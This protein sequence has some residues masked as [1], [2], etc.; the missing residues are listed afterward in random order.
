MGP[1]LLRKLYRTPLIPQGRRA[2]QAM[3]WVVCENRLPACTRRGLRIPR[4]SRGGAGVRPHGGRVVRGSRGA[5]LPRGVAGG[6][7]GQGVRRGRGETQGPA[8]ESRPGQEAKEQ[9]GKEEERPAQSRESGS[10]AS[11]LVARA[12]PGE[13]ATDRH[14][15]HLRRH[16]GAY[17]RIS[18]SVVGSRGLAL[19]L[20]F[21][22]YPTCREDSSEAILSGPGAARGRG[23]F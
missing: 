8:G 5:E 21:S 6:K 7:A 16:W 15:R 17:L 22:G 13:P 19:I 18:H 4:G 12:P 23:L 9:G 2:R 20:S 3:P 14:G 10:G 1:L 11:A